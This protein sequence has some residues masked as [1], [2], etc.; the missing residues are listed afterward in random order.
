MTTVPRLGDTYKV[1]PSIT[2]ATLNHLRVYAES[3]AV[4]FWLGRVNDK[5][6]G[7][8]TDLWVP[9]FTATA[10]S[11]DVAPI[12]MLR[13]KTYLDESDLCLLAQVHS[14]PGAAF[15]SRRDDF[16]A[17]SPWP[18]F[19]SIVVPNGGGISGRFWELVEVCELLGAGEWRRLNQGEK[20]RRFEESEPK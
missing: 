2:K 12:E 15:H 8:V 14:H 13:L 5:G 6:P 3:E 18:G 4:C 16:N 17:A 19:I 11:Y 1:P 7:V 20:A 10:V 9:R